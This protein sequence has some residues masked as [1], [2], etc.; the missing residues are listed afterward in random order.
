MITR[1]IV[2]ILKKAEYK[3][4]TPPLHVADLSFDFDAALVGPQ[5]QG[6]LVLVAEA[7]DESLKD[8]RRRLKSLMMVLE[9]TGSRRPV[10]LV[11]ATDSHD[12][13]IL[14]GISRL[15]RLVRVSPDNTAKTLR[16]R[17]QPLLPLD[18]P[19]PIQPVRL[20]R[21]DFTA[22]FQ[23]DI[24][25]KLLKDL[26]DAAEQGSEL[27]KETFLRHLGECIGREEDSHD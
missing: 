10:S 21:E 16:T 2:S 14:E 18:L 12:Q 8:L 5:D 13:E 22:T 25:S 4:A 15:C 23:D 19:R 26:I 1:K 3:Q 27:V 17:L 24:P 7:T 11:L 9:R 20:R 6:N